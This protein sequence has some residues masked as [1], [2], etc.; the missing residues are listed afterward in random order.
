MKLN[1]PI[2]VMPGVGP[3]KEQNFSA[4]KIRTVYDLLHHYPRGYLDLTQAVPIFM[5]QDGDTVCVRA[6]ITRKMQGAYLP[7]RGGKRGMRIF[8]LY[9]ADDSGSMTVSFFNQP[10]L[11]DSLSTGETYYFYGKLTRGDHGAQMASP[12]CFLAETAP[13]VLPVYPQTAGINNKFLQE[14]VKKAFVECKDQLSDPLPKKLRQRLSLLSVVQAVSQIHYPQDMKLL[15]AAKR[16]FAFEE[17]L[18]FQLGLSQMHRERMELR[19]GRLEDTDISSFYASLPFALTNA[20]E[21][22]INDCIGDFSKMIPMNR[23]I[24]GDVGSGKTMVAAAAVYLMAKNGKQSAFM[25]PTELLAVQHY[26]NLCKLFEPL[27]ITCVLL[28]GGL[29]AKEKRNAHEMI[30]TGAAKVVI[31]THALISQGVEFADLGLVIT[32]E[33]HRFGVNQRGLLQKKG[34][35]SHTLIMSATPIPRTLALLVYGDLDVSIID[36]LPK[37]RMPIETYALPNEKRV[38]ALK[39]VLKEVEKGRQAYIVCP[40]VEDGQ[41]DLISVTAY[42]DAL[43]KTPLGTLNT[44]VLH[45]KMKS[46]EK[47]AVMKAFAAG[48]IQ[49]LIATTVIEVGI[50]VPNA[51]VML[52]ENA[53]RFGLSQLH[54]LRGRVGRGSEQSY[55]LLLAEHTTER[56]EIMTKTQDGFELAKED[57]RLRGSGDFFGDQQHGLPPF[58]LQK[59]MNDPSLIEQAKITADEIV[60]EDPELNGKYAQLG[61]AVARLFSRNE[62]QSF[63]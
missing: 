44:A 40:A 63:N 15:D 24:Q 13:H 14:L 4:L 20:Q 58:K 61:E 16:R 55:C 53:D 30:Q 25:A 12:Q 34:E 18:S 2:T 46:A 33:Q 31:G 43:K 62:Q 50:D 37:G 32:D 19:G 17:M 10:Y 60:T 57:L 51:T 49:L 11:F 28:T 45:G 27:G 38:R 21:N 6:V 5:A 36:E 26:D 22:A 41:T 42:A 7:N 56:I 3:K 35:Y 59:A 47:D 9:A 54:Q 8:K 23:L 29:R 1:D 48:E 52:V 39:F